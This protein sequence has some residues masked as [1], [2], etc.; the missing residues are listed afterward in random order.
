MHITIQLHRFRRSSERP[1]PVPAV[2][3]NEWL[4]PKPIAKK[5]TDWDK[6]RS[7]ISYLKSQGSSASNAAGLS[8][9]DPDAPGTIRTSE[10]RSED[11]GVESASPQEQTPQ[12]ARKSPTARRATTFKLRRP[13]WTI[14]WSATRIL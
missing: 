4:T 9:P 12:N 11:S 3:N 14:L 10:A 6:F 7:A 1:H 8:N 2:R 5:S 13:L